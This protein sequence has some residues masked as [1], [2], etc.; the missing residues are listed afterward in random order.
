[1]TFV[2]LNTAG[3]GGLLLSRRHA[4]ARD[5]R[6]IEEGARASMMTD[7]VCLFPLFFASRRPVLLPSQAAVAAP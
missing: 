1:M 2:S 4:D 5:K 6:G 3:G 7:G